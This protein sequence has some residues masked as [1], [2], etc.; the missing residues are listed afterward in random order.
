M[1]KSEFDENILNEL[2]Q[3]K[4]PPKVKELLKR[5]LRYEMDAHGKYQYD[6]YDRI[7]EKVMKEKWL[8]LKE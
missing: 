6:D 1:H 2:A 5:I 7:I 3:Q 8:Y 4:I